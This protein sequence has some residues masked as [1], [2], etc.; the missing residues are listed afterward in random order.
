M[1]KE[2][3]TQTKPKYVQAKFCM[4]ASPLSIFSAQSDP[5]VHLRG[6]LF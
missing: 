5:F 3:L 2:A 1:K 4:L 6:L